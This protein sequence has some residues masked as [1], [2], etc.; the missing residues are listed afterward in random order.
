MADRTSHTAHI[1]YGTPFYGSD[2]FG[3][4]YFFD[5]CD[6]SIVCH[7]NP[8]PPAWREPTAS[9]S[10]QRAALGWWSLSGAVSLLGSCV[11]P[12]FWTSRRQRTKSAGARD[13]KVLKLADETWRGRCWWCG[14]G[15]YLFGRQHDRGIVRDTPAADPVGSAPY[16]LGRQLASL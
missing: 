5:D 4:I 10:T 13:C 9:A 6:H 12:L 14:L 1:F 2:T 16:C 11:T 8:K 15:A 7:G 3:W